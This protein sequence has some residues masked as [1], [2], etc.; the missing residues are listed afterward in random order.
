MRRETLSHRS[1]AIG[2]LAVGLSACNG[3]NG[4]INNAPGQALPS[5]SQAQAPLKRVHHDGSSGKIQHVV[6]IIQENRS[7]NN[8]FYG[9]PG[10]TTTTYGYNA[11]GQKLRCSRLGSRRTGISTIVRLRSSI[12][13]TARAAF[14]ARIA[15]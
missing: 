6:I 2:A 9:F 10:A 15:G 4:L 3:N 1:L 14:P 11:S 8:L 7:F 13:A 5:Q 12:R